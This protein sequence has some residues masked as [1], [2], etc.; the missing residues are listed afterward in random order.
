[1]LFREVLSTP[2]YTVPVFICTWHATKTWIEQIRNKLIN[3]DLYTEAFNGLHGIMTMDPDGTHEE[4]L[5]A[6]DSAIGDW[7]EQF[8]AEDGMVKWF[9]KYWEPKKGILRCCT[10]AC[11]QSTAH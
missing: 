4:R 11:N 6:V 5:A 1:M 10:F 3:K 2:G 7:K 8:R 9:T